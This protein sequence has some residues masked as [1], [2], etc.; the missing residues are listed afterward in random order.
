MIEQLSTELEEEGFFFALLVKISAHWSLLLIRTGMDTLLRNWS[1]PYKKTKLRVRAWRVTMAPRQLR[2]EPTEVNPTADKG[3]K[4]VR[5]DSND[6]SSSQV[7]LRA[8][9]IAWCLS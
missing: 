5:V 9:A 1:R 6:E 7:R 8:R 2:L 4:R 3:A